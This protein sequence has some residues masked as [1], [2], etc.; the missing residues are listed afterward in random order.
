MVLIHSHF[1]NLSEQCKKPITNRGTW[2]NDH[3][4][5]AGNILFSLEANNNWTRGNAVE[6][7]F[8]PQ[9][10]VVNIGY[11]NVNVNDDWTYVRNVQDQ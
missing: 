1:I 7:V 2:N 8:P 6:M 11:K 9:I 5:E 3:F 10:D 4:G